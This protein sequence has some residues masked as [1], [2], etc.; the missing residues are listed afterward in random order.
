MIDFH[1]IST[2]LLGLVA[3]FI[4]GKIMPGEEPGGIWGTLTFG[5]IGS[6]VGRFAFNKLG[7]YEDNNIMSLIA[8]VVGACL[9]IF[10][11]KKLIAPRLGGGNDA[12]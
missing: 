6:F 12:A 5:I 10:I 3:G 4:A 1:L 7:L 8:S 9:I 11:W 2:P